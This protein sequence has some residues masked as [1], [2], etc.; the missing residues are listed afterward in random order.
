MFG[1]R[2]RVLTGVVLGTLAGTGLVVG[3]GC[4]TTPRTEAERTSLD[5]ESRAA[6]ARMVE[7]DPSLRDF[8]GR[9]YGY[10][11]FPSVGKGG[12]GVG[13]SYGRG[14]VYEQGR[15]VG[16]ADMTQGTIGLQIG[17]QS[18][19][20]IIAFQTPNR[21]NDFRSGNFTFAANASAVAIKAGAAS[22]TDFKDGTAVFTDSEAGLMAEAAVGGQ[23]FTFQ[24]LSVGEPMN[25]STT[26][27]RGSG[28]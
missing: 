6:Y 11:I 15:P 5:Q 8:I 14:I 4:S 1:I 16:Y 3:V 7:K 19:S 18:F 22:A 24:P 9:S 21:L 20:Q 27:Y 10:V 25:S 26:G 23:R 2:S 28:Y 17:G 13:G 12:L